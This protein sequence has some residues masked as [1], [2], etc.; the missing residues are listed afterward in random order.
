MVSPLL[1]QEEEYYSKLQREGEERQ[2][3]VR[4]IAEDRRAKEEGRIA[5]V[6]VQS[7]EWWAGPLLMLGKALFPMGGGG[8]GSQALYTISSSPFGFCRI[9]PVGDGK[10]LKETGLTIKQ[11][12]PHFL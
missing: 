4:M 1:V 11:S 12:T 6:Q 3:R 10:G 5:Q 2:A 8:G 9:G 7:R